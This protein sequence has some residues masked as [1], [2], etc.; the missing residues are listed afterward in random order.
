MKKIIVGNW[1]MHGDAAMAHTLAMDV[2]DAA[3][4]APHEVVICPPALLLSQ[5]A[6][7]L[8][9]S[10]VKLGG[11]D[12]SPEA[13]GAFTGDISAPMLKAAGC[14]YV[15]VGHSERRQHHGETN[16]TVRA[17][18]ARALASGLIPIICVG[19]TAGERD[20]GKTLETVTQ[21]VKECLPSHQPIATS[22]YFLLAYEPVWAIG[23]GKIPTQADIG[24]MHAAILEAA[25]KP[26]SILYGGSVKPENAREIMAI[27]HVSGVL[28][29]GASVKA[30]EFCKIIRD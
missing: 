30:E 1:K 12:C 10:S 26:L 7:A 28:V 2:A 29:G 6:T 23:S 25:A 13:E 4:K 9:G 21:Q 22:P 5:V 24:Q 14:A 17:K 15:I 19:E 27:P 18:A 8:I 16:A 3:A 11:Q 20:A